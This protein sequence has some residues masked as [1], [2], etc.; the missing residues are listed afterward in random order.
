MEKALR[1]VHSPKLNRPYYIDPM[2]TDPIEGIACFSEAEIDILKTRGR[3]I[4]LGLL[5]KIFDAKE[6]FGATLI[7]L[8]PDAEPRPRGSEA[9]PAPPRAEPPTFVTTPPEHLPYSQEKRR[10]IARKN[11]AAI[12]EVIR[13][14][15]IRT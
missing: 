6:V 4:N 2:R 1:K 8:F 14:T 15:R 10:E 11:L 3:N 13:N 5:E 12:T 7:V 9:E